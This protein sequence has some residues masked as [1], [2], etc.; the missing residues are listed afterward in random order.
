MKWVIYAGGGYFF[1][2]TEG[3][4]F[5]SKWAGLW[6][7][8]YK[9]LGSIK[10]S[11]I[12]SSKCSENGLTIKIAKSK[13]PVILE[14]GFELRTKEEDKNYEDNKI[15]KTSRIIRVKNSVSEAVV[16]SSTRMKIVKQEYK[17]D[18]PG[19]DLKYEK[20]NE[21]P[22]RKHI[23][24]L[25]I[26]AI[27]GAELKITRRRAETTS[28]E[29]T[30]TPELKEFAS[31][32]DLSVFE[33]QE[34]ENSG[35]F[36]AGYPYFTMNW[37]RDSAYA[38]L[39]YNTLGNFEHSKTALKFLAHYQ[40]E[41]K[42][43]NWVYS[44]G[45]KA[46][47]DSC[48]STPLWL[49]ALSDYLLKSGDTKFMT[50]M[51]TNINSAIEYYKKNSDKDGL[52]TCNS[53]TWMDTIERKGK[54]IEV[55]AFWYLAFKNLGR[56]TGDKSYIDASKK[57]KNSVL[58]KYKDG[59]WFRDTLEN[60]RRTINPIFLLWAGMVD[61]HDADR[62][63]RVIESPEFTT[64]RGVRTMS[65]WDNNFDNGYHTGA[66]WGF[67]TG[68][69]AMSAV[70]YRKKKTAKKYLEIQKKNVGLRCINKL[71][72]Y[73]TNRPQGCLSQLWSACILPHAII[74]YNKL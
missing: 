73:Y 19:E 27:N 52:I 3:M 14:I 49:V 64:K 32:Y 72:E 1:L 9:L 22:T 28:A 59:D 37:G 5:P 34:F 41:R 48:D 56:L 44:D 47:Y 7:G 68:I 18:F 71:D 45:S 29:K 21:T 65:S 2:T 51:E 69:A 15:A 6:F 46:D 16:K 26:D 38:I 58:S 25:E 74:E 20:W 50:E 12:Y 57:I 40:R 13:S 67:L 30:H 31:L 8:Q 53:S 39:S 42:M 54:P 62:M 36:F 66:V 4:E 35:G 23:I 24:T 43:P 10:S 17:E 60:K 63:L 11:E 33:T 55:Q 61:E 70:K